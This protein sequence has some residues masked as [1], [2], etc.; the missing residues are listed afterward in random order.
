MNIEEIQFLAK[1]LPHDSVYWASCHSSD[2]LELTT[3]K[4][5]KA[6]SDLAFP[7]HWVKALHKDSVSWPK[8]CEG[9]LLWRLY[10]HFRGNPIAPNSPL[11]FALA[12]RTPELRPMENALQAFLLTNDSLPEISKKLGIPTDVIETYQDLFW[13]VRARAQE[14]LFIASQ[15]YPSTRSVEMTDTYLKEVPPGL[16]LKRAAWNG[17]SDGLSWLVGL[18]SKDKTLPMTGIS[19]AELEARIMDNGVQ[20]AKLGF[21]NSRNT[22]IGQARSILLA[23][24]ASGQETDAVDDSP[25]ADCGESILKELQSIS[26][27]QTSL[28]IN[29]S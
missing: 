15:L 20:L 3:Q 26:K 2:G 21:I 22:G 6:Y 12:L 4:W 29:N 10:W 13:P 28:R 25:A 11:Q 16:L 27:K 18:S 7:F 8:E 24:K 14:T 19:A 17:S 9:D 1:L 23:A 5:V